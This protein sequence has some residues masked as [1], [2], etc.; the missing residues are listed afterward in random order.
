MASDFHSPPSGIHVRTSLGGPL[1]TAQDSNRNTPFRLSFRQTQHLQK[2]FLLG[3]IRVNC[4]PKSIWDPKSRSNPVSY[5]QGQLKLQEFHL[6]SPTAQVV[7]LEAVA[8][9]LGITSTLP[10][11]HQRT[12]WS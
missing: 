9:S 4:D 1:G 11:F 8:L 2:L 12:H 10:N 5:K 6:L 3:F 7:Q